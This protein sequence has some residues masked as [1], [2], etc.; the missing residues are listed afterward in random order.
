MAAMARTGLSPRVKSIKVFEITAADRVGLRP[1][2]PSTSNEAN[3]LGASL[4]SWAF[5]LIYTHE[6]EVEP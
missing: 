6:V 3:V 4:A 1:E 5:E 2:D